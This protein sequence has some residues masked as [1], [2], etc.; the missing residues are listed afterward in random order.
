MGTSIKV[1]LPAMVRRFYESVMPHK[2]L[3]NSNA[4]FKVEINTDRD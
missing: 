2:V 1:I 3:T 4:R